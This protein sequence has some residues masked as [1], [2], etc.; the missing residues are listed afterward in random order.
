MFEALFKYIPRINETFSR[1][2]LFNGTPSTAS[3]IQF[4][5]PVTKSRQV[6][7]RGDCL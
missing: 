2:C 1:L 7:E 3:V 4:C 6:Q 5:M